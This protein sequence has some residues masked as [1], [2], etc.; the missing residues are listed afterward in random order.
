MNAES[1]NW[2][3]GLVAFFLTAVTMGPWLYRLITNS[4][5]RQRVMQTGVDATATIIKTWDTGTRIN[6]NP[7]V[8]MLLNVIPKPGVAPFEAELVHTVSIVQL[9]LFQPGAQLNVKYD[10]A[11]PSHVAIVSVIASGAA[12]AGGAVTYSLLD[13][14]QAEQMLTQHQSANEKLM[15]GPQ[16]TAKVLQYMPLGPTVNGNN[17]A[18]NL[19]LEVYPPSGTAFT[20]QAEG[21]VIAEASV[22][23]YQPGQMITVRYDPFDQTKVAVEHSGV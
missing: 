1:L 11:K 23:K 16:A 18:V 21:I 6:N 7:Q 13:A 5:T 9:P 19:I 20:A 2:I 14:Q 15:S 22:P 10:P 3:F 12:A 4:R 8:G 17:P